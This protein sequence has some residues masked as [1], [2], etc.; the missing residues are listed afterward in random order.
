MS[1]SQANERCKMLFILSIWVIILSTIKTGNATDLMDL[2]LSISSKSV[3]IQATLTDAD[4]DHKYFIQESISASDSPIKGKIVISAGKDSYKVYYN[5]AS[6]FNKERLVIHDKNCLPFSYENNWDKTL[7][8]IDK[9]VTNLILLMGPSILYRLD[10]SSL[11]WKSVEDKNIR[12]TM[13]KGATTFINV[14]LRI[15]YYYKKHFDD[16]YGIKNPSR[17][18][19]KGKDPSSTSLD[20]YEHLILDIYLQ[21]ESNH[22]NL[23]N[24]VKPLPG[25]G[26]PYY[27]SMG[28][29]PFPQLKPNYVHFSMYEYVKGSINTQTFSEIHASE[30]YNILRIKSNVLGVTTEVIY[31]YNLGLSYLFQKGGT[32]S[33]LFTDLNSPGIN[34][35]GHFY[36][37]D[38]FLVNSIFK[39]LGKI[40]LEHRSGYP[41]DVWETTKYAVNING[42]RVD[43]AVIS[44]YFAESRDSVIFHGYTLV[45]TTIE[46]YKFDRSKKTYTW[47][48]EI[49]RDYM[50]FETAGAEDEL[51]D[52]FTLKE[53]KYLYKD[54][55]L[56]LAFK[57]QPEDGGH[58]SQQLIESHIYEMKQNF[59]YFI[60]SSETISP[61]RIETV[62][63]NFNDEQLQVDVTFL[64][65]PDFQYILNSQTMSVSAFTFRKMKII[66]TKDE[67]ECLNKLSTFIDTINVVIY[68]PSDS[69]CGYLTNFDDFMEDTKFGEPC[70]VYHFPL[71]NLR[72]INQELPLDQIHDIFLKDVGN[73]YWLI[74]LNGENFATYKLIDVID[75]TKNQGD[76]SDSFVFK[77]K[78]NEKLKSNDQV[79]VTVP[80]SK[81]FADCYRACH[82]S[83]QLECNIFSFCSNGD[84]RV[85]SLLT[86]DLYNESHVEQ[87]KTCSIYASEVLNDYSEVP[88]R[89]F[90]T[91]TSIAIET[92]LDTC[93]ELCHASPDCLSFQYCNLKCSFG[94]AYTDEST[95]YDEECIVFVPKVSEKY[96]KTGN[97][98][99][100]GVIHTEFNLNFEQCASL[101]H[102]WSDGETGCKSFNYCP[103]S[104]TESSCSL[105]EFSVK[106]SNIKTTEGGYC[107]NYE[108]QVESN[109]K[110]SKGSS[111]ATKGTS[112][113]G[114]FGIIMLFLLVGGLLGFAA[115]FGYTKV[116]QIRNAS[117]ANHNFSWTRQVN[118]QTENIN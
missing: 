106:S 90:K 117:R 39:Y 93:A 49:T 34:S 66:K 10:H 54:K 92:R 101:C 58:F 69:S 99:V 89:K 80:D 36:L 85:S 84:C 81:T 51:H 27:F 116:K 52:I 42:K 78:D 68:R 64:D 75:V 35:N 15:T 107:S 8:G 53:C 71:N 88:H 110:R 115:P 4:V 12:G 23:A 47:V 98:I 95:E 94:G 9:P 11:V 29:P 57:L 79:T 37:D 33:I 43:K 103:K 21:N 44:Q 60:I 55:K 114:A 102:E 112:G 17:I 113:S 18:V 41:V 74:S 24:E 104:K 118:E 65:L 109:G 32:C 82:N 13:M 31:D 100:S 22:D 83:D 97:K 62:Q 5:T 91:Q 108:L 63:Y 16:D 76:S 46:M 40:N 96:Q 67:N 28:D 30:K 25:I 26:C 73:S 77:I 56:T 70:S 61:L 3:N 38:L 59:L 20:Y 48:D 6:N 72:R 2:P 19:F 111:G 50:N 7:P 105:T 87:E 1:S 86:D 45:S 14:R